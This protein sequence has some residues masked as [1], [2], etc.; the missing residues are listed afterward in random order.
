MKTLK[1]KFKPEDLQIGDILDIGKGDIGIILSKRKMT[2]LNDY[3]FDILL[4]I[5]SRSKDKF[6]FGC[7][8]SSYFIE[9]DRVIKYK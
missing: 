2:T 4:Y 3:D 5:K 8:T 9:T 6:E 7:W 1:H